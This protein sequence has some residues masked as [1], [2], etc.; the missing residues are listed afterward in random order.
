MNVNDLIFPDDN[1]PSQPTLRLG[2][3]VSAG[4]SFYIIASPEDGRLLA[5]NLDTGLALNSG[6]ATNI[7]G[8]K[9]WRVAL[10]RKEA[11]A[12][13]GKLAAWRVTNP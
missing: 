13:L 8:T 2:S 4:N 3:R 5:I 11:A 10:T 6:L 9:D 12:I 7:R 1:P